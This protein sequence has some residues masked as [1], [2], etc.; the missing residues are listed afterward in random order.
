MTSSGVPIISSAPLAKITPTTP[1]T[2]PLMS[3]IIIEVCTVLDLSLI[4]IYNIVHALLQREDIE[5]VYW[6]GDAGKEGQTIEAVSYT[7]L[8][9]YKRQSRYR[10]DIFG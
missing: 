8:D 7:H 1:I 5:R 2:I 4:H 6:A 9:V 10:L 3:A